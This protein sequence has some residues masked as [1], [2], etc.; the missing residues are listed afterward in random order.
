MQSG[1]VCASAWQDRKVVMIMYTNSDPQ[2][3]TY[4]PRRQTNGSRDEL[5]PLLSLPTTKT[6]QLM[7]KAINPEDI[8]TVGSKAESSINIY[9]IFSLM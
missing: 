7:I 3:V 5:S 1:K 8:I 4:V 9:I 6:W 2:C